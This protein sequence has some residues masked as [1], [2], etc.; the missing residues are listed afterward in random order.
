M[1][2]QERLLLEA[3]ANM[4]KNE[5]ELGL[6]FHDSEETSHYFQYNWEN[7]NDAFSLEV[8]DSPFYDSI[9][10]AFYE[11]HSY[12]YVNDP[13]FYESFK[14]SLDARAI[15]DD[16]QKQ[17]IDGMSKVLK[18]FGIKGDERHGG[19][20]PNMD[21]LRDLTSNADT[22]GS[23]PSDAFTGGGPVPGDN[24]IN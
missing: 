22:K 9:H 5:P 10:S 24:E 15:P 20:N 8:M 18:D 14:R 13:S 3:I 6:S 16:Q 17:A 2:K 12:K 21:E 23:T 11:V 1:K 4:V 7:L 19:W